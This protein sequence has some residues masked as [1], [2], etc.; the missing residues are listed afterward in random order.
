MSV[1]A[2]VLIAVVSRRKKWLISIVYVE[3]ISKTL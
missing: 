2:M 1:V 3:I